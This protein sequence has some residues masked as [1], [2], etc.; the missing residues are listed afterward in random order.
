ML[1]IT[2]PRTMKM[3]MT[4]IRHSVALSN[5]CPGRVT[6]W[7][8][9]SMPR[10]VQHSS[11]Q[12]KVPLTQFFHAYSAN[13]TRN[14]IACRNP[15]GTLGC[16]PAQTSCP[17][18]EQLSKASVKQVYQHNIAGR[19]YGNAKLY[20]QWRYIISFQHATICPPWDLWPGQMSIP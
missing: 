1:Q 13:K 4:S 9:M 14:C 12:H 10:C 16:P 7:Q 17:D 15:G 20:M 11:K 19:M 6:L 18:T 3:Y 2:C 5:K 8:D